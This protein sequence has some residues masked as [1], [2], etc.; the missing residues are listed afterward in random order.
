M[1]NTHPVIHMEKRK[2]DRGKTDKINKTS[3]GEVVTESRG[4]RSRDG[5]KE[6]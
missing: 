1:G 5:R 3:V 2:K 6:N 4:P